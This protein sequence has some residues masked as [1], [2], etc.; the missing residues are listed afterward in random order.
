[1][2]SLLLIRIKWILLKYNAACIRHLVGV[3][4]C[5]SERSKDATCGSDIDEATGHYDYFLCRETTILC[6]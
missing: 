6:Y 3:V 4:S 2:G 5:E 1:M